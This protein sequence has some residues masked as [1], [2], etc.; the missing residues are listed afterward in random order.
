ME[1]KEIARLVATRIAIDLILAEIQR[2]DDLIH[3]VSDR[4]FTTQQYDKQN[5][6]VDALAEIAAE[7]DKA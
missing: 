4:L 7:L 2:R 1:K 6:V 5:A 3:R